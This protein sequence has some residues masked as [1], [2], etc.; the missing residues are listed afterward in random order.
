MT[1]ST[2]LRDPS[3]HAAP[4]NLRSLTR[5]L[6]RRRLVVI[7]V[8]A[9]IGGIVSIGLAL[10]ERQYTA[11]TRVAVTPAPE[12]GQSPA[13]YE[14]LLSTMAGVAETLPVL[15]QVSSSVSA[16]SLRQLQERVHSSVVPGTVTIKVSVTDPDPEVA[17]QVANE[18]VAVLPQH[19]PSDGA[20]QFTTTEPAAVP[21]SF[22]S[23]NIKVTVLAATLLAVALAVAAAVTYDRVTKT[24]ETP[25]EAAA[26]NDI[27]VLG[28]IARPGSVDSVP[29]SDPSSREFASLRTLRVAL[30][31]AMSSNP[32]RLLVVSPVATDPWSGWLE[33]NLSVSLAELGHRVL[34]I[35]AHRGDQHRHPAL[36]ADGE[37]GLYDLLAGAV[38]LDDA[39]RPGPVP[40][41]SVVPLGNIDLA[42]PSLLEMRFRQLIDEIDAS[43][44]VIVLHAAPVSES[45]DARIMAIAGGVL[46]TIPS[47]RVASSALDRAI[48]DLRAVGSRIVGS[49]LLGVRSSRT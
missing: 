33:V 7:V 35:D 49:V 36:S 38:D 26:D 19:D 45:D 30:E 13:N 34:L 27:P 18:I 11:S 44:D 22:S 46:L 10:A 43:Y 47:G 41:V 3:T 8:V 48:D 25:Q 40:K 31:F 1:R 9:L 20:F 12:S 29:A 5:L 24:V 17:A 21:T 16:R 2:G 37:P 4:L 23:P 15:E 32:T 14:S 6:W 28:V 42:A 39:V